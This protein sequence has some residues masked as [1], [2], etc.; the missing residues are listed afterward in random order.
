MFQES[1][2]CV[3]ADLVLLDYDVCHKPTPLES[4]L[5]SH[6]ICHEKADSV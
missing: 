2:L 5:P 1:H 3:V 4:S 6:T